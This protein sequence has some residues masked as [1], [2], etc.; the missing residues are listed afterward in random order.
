MQSELAKRTI[1]GE[2]K[3]YSPIGGK[4]PFDLFR[5]VLLRTVSNSRIGSS[6]SPLSVCSSDLSTPCLPSSSCAVLGPQV[7][8]A[9]YPSSGST[10][11]RKLYEGLVGYNSSTVYVKPEKRIHFAEIGYYSICL[12]VWISLVCVCFD[13]NVS[14]HSNTVSGMLAL[15]RTGCVPFLCRCIDMF[16]PLLSQPG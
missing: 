2:T 3:P 14:R 13:T 6:L 10:W 5:R 9:S 12:A 11:L 16:P 15:T 7:L 1:A 8:V 4:F